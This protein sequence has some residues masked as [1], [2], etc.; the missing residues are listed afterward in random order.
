MGIPGVPYVD[1]T[2]Q[3][4]R[5]S[6]N[7]ALQM[8]IRSLWNPSV[9]YSKLPFSKL[10]RHGRLPHSKL[11]WLDSLLAWTV[12]EE[13]GT[14]G[15][16]FE[17]MQLQM[18][19]MADRPAKVKARPMTGGPAGPDRRHTLVCGGWSLNTKRAVRLQQLKQA[20]DGK[21]LQNSFNAGPF[22]AVL[23]CNFSRS[24]P[25]DESD[26]RASVMHI[27]QVINAI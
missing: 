24:R 16:A 4:R 20:L 6:L 21:G 27:M 8:G 12:E 26:H 15:S 17:D 2:P 1:V 7:Q 19:E 13:V 18:R 14:Q 3:R 5:K 11:S 9:H 22:C 25:E 10:S 23:L